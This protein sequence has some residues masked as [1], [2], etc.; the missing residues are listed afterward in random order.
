METLFLE[1]SNTWLNT[2]YATGPSE[3]QRRKPS[4][5]AED[6][7]RIADSSAELLDMIMVAEKSRGVYFSV[8]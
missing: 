4:P 2:R 8:C 5:W 7:L 3:A 1:L 6:N